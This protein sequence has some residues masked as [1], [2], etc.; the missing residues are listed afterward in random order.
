NPGWQWD[1]V[2]EKVDRISLP[3]FEKYRDRWERAWKRSDREFVT[4]YGHSS[5]YSYHHKSAMSIYG[6]WTRGDNLSGVDLAVIDKYPDLNWCWPMLCSHSELTLGFIERHLQKLWRNQ[7]L[8]KHTCITLEFIQEKNLNRC[9]TLTVTG[10]SLNP[11]V[12]VEFLLAHPECFEEGLLASNPNL[13]MEMID[14]LDETFHF[15]SSKSS[16][17][18]RRN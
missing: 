15:L 12:T 9:N 13:T 11:S 17:I 18:Q 6:Y 8:Y 10:I 14:K 5:H 3:F 1:W 7:A 16:S 4:L 2:F